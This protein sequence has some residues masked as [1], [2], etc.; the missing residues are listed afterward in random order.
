[1]QSSDDLSIIS[2]VIGMANAFGMRVIAEGVESVEQG[3]LLLRLGCQQAQGYGI[4][5]PMPADEFPAWRQS[6]KAEASWLG[7]QPVEDQ[8]LPLLYAAVEHRYWVK[9]LEKKILGES[10]GA[11]VLDSHLCKLG[12]W[13]ENETQSRLGLQTKFSC[14]VNLHRDLHTLGQKAIALQAKGDVRAA[15]KLL[16]KIRQQCD[17]LL[18]ELRALIS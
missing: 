2:G 6:W 17:L 12:A 1:M 11:P 7:L 15:L 16:P 5:R 9:M 18:I 3:S 13:I 4:A 14:M 8:N 10:I